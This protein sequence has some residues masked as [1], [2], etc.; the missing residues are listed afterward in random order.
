LNSHRNFEKSLPKKLQG[1]PPVERVALQAIADSLRGE[2]RQK[3]LS[4]EEWQRE[5]D[6][7][8]QRHALSHLLPFNSAGN[9]EQKP[10]NYGGRQKLSRGVEFS[11]EIC[12]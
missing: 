7:A 8:M 10:L 3:R 4:P 2:R 12:V 1:W 5:L 6:A 11:E 9:A